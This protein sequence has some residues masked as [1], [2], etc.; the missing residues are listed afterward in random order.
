MDYDVFLSHSSKDRT[1]VDR[2]KAELEGLGYRVCVDYEVLPEIDP[3]EVTR[4]TANALLE[5][6]R[7]CAALIYVLAPGA[8]SS[9]W[10]PWEMGVFDGS[11]GRVFV[12]PEGGETEM[13][14]RDRRYTDL[15]PVVPAENRRAFLEKHLPRRVRELAQVAPLRLDKF[16]PPQP[17]IFDYAQQMATAM[18]GRELPA[19]LGDPGQ[20]MQAV[21]EIWTAWWR[22]WGL[23]PPPVRP[24]A[25]R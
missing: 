6:M 21:T 5:A 23:L 13:Y 20:A 2:V 8:E 3:Q 4:D 12:W 16:E 7:E 24:G 18:F 17:Q 14:A 22:L 25:K 9:N 19:R 10:M 1:A 15:Y 11:R